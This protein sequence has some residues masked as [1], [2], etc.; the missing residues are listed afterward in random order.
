MSDPSRV[1][2]EVRPFSDEDAREWRRE[3]PALATTVHLANCSHSPQSKRVRAAI[4]AYLDSWLELGMDWDLWIAE[5][6]RAREEFARLIGAGKGEVAVSTSASAAVASIASA[7]DAAGPRRRVVTTEAEFPTVG[8]VWLAHEKYGFDVDFVPV[9]DG[10]VALDDYERMIDERT[11]ITSATHIYYQNGFKQDIGRIAQIAHAAGS[12]L[13][14]DAYQSLGTCRVDVAELDVDILVSGNLKY[15]LGVPGIAFIYVKEELIERLK[16]ALTGWFGRRQ[17]F[18]FD[19]KM[20]DYAGD[21]RRF[22]TGTPPI[23]A[24]AAARAG[25]EIIRDVGVQRIERRIEELS[26]YSIAAARTREL[27]YVGPEDPRCKGA[28]NAI[29]VTDPHRV[30]EALK[31]RDVV[32]SARGDVIRIAP[33]FFTTT[34]DIERAMDELH[35]VLHRGGRVDRPRRTR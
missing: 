11:L 18:A 35:S 13:L 20:L 8:H 14:V 5:V 33:H 7:L 19:A 25:M 22:E 31:E 3:F 16:P 15:L 2:D 23:F 30:E 32:A 21:A 27:D 24:A 28:T 4:E 1:P 10:A 34:D 9:R 6:A 12:L 17:P 29:R 26:E